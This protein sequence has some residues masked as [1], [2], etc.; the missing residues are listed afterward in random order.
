LLERKKAMPP[1]EEPF[2]LAFVTAYP[3][4]RG[5]LSEYAEALLDAMIRRKR[6]LRIVVHSDQPHAGGPRLVVKPSWVPDNPFSLITLFIK[7]LRSRAPIIHF[8]VHFAVFGRSR[9]SNFLGFLAIKLVNLFKSLFHVKTVLTLHN[10]PE[11]INVECM[12]L[13]RSFINK[14]GF[15]VAEKMSMSCDRVVVHLQLYRKL[16][17]HRFRRDVTHIPHGS[18]HLAK[19]QEASRKDSLMFIG[20]LSPAKDLEVLKEA[21]LKVKSKYPWVKLFLSTSPHPNFPETIHQLEVLRGVEG[22]EVLGYVP[23]HALPNYLA[24][25]I[26]V[27]L[28]YKTATGS[29]GVVHLVASL[30]I[31]VIATDLPDMRELRKRGAGIML[32]PLSSDKICEAVEKL[33]ENEGLRDELSRKNLEFSQKYSWDAVA[34]AYLDLYRELIA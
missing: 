2:H 33:M 19:E 4:D 25:S 17:Q 32:V 3:P 20:Y 26:A 5:R 24:R 7:L 29:S 1:T 23:N 34:E 8:N 21:Y 14:L 18:W 10:M 30:G 15:L 16:L 6:R 11:A 12:K 13:R 22:I 31:P 9:L 27:V 28:P